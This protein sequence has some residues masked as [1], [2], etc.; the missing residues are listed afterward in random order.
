MKRTWKQIGSLILS[1]C[2]VMTMLPTTAFAETGTKDSGAGLGTSGEITAFAALDA[3]IAAQTVE[4]GTAEEELNLPTELTV[5]VTRTVTVTTGSA[6]TADVSG[7]DTATD[8][9]AQEPETQ[10][11]TQKIAEE[12]TVDVSGWTSAPAYDGDTEGDYVFTPTLALPDGVTLATGVSAPQ[13]T[14]TVGAVAPMA[15]L[16]STGDTV[17]ITGKDISTIQSAIAN[18]LSSNSTVTVEGTKTGV[19]EA[20]ELT[21][22]ENKTVIWQATYTG[23]NAFISLVGKGSFEVAAGGDINNASTNATISSGGD[24]TVSG[25]TVSSAA[26]NTIE[27]S[28]NITVSDG[29]VSTAGEGGYAINSDGNG[30]VTVEGG[31]VSATGQN[32]NA[33]NS[34]GNGNVTV[35]GGTVSATGQNG[36]AIKSYGN[37]NITVEGGTVSATTGR[38]IYANGS[39][40]TVIVSGGTV[41]NAIEAPGTS[42]TVIV[43]GGTVSSATGGNAILA[44]GASATVTV[45]GGTV[46]ATEGIAILAT[47]ASA[48]V[49]VND[50]V[51]FAYKSEIRNVNNQAVIIS[52]SASIN[53]PGVVLGWDTQTTTYAANATTDI[54][55]EPATATAYWDNSAGVGGIRYAN[56]T[57]TG[58]LPVEGV[59]V[60][61]ASAPQALPVPAAPTLAWNQDD[62]FTLSWPAVPNAM[63][64]QVRIYKDGTKFYENFTTAN[65]LPDGEFQDAGSYTFSVAAIGD[66]VNYLS[67]QHSPQSV[68]YVYPRVSTGVT[69]TMDIGG[70]TDV[71]L[72]SNHSGTGWAW[73]ATTAT[74]TLS[75]GY[76]GGRIAII[77]AAS[78]TVNLVYTGAVSINASD[79]DSAIHCS[80]SLSISGTDGTLALTSPSYAL[81]A[82]GDLEITGGTV[83]AAATGADGSG[84]ASQ[85]SNITIS[86]SANVTASGA[87]TG[88]SYGIRVQ[89]GDLTIST[90]GTVTATGKQYGIC[91]T[92]TTISG[93]TVKLN[94]SKPKPDDSNNTVIN[95][96]TVIYNNGTPP[97]ITGISP[98]SGVL[99]GGT[100]VT[101]T[102]TGFAAG[103]TVKIG[104]AAA[105]G[106][107]VTSATEITCIVP[108][109]SVGKANVLV[110][111]SGGAMAM[112]EGFTYTVGGP[113]FFN[114]AT[115]TFNLANLPAGNTIGGSGNTAWTWGNSDKKLTLTGAGPYTLTGTAS[116]N[117]RVVANTAVD[118]TLDSASFTSDTDETAL[119]L[120][121]GGTLKVTADSQV[122]GAIRG[123]FGS[124]AI[125]LNDADLD[126]DGEY[127][128][129]DVNS[130]SLTGNGTVAAVASGGVAVNCVGDLEVGIG[131]TLSASG[132]GGLIFQD[133]FSGAA[134]VISGGGNITATGDTYYGI[135]GNSLTSSLTFDFTGSLE[136]TGATYGI[137]MLK[138]DTATVVSFVSAPR[139]LTINSVSGII[140]SSQGG[141]VALQNNANIPG[142]NEVFNA[143]GTSFPI[144]PAPA[145][146]NVLGVAVNDANK[147]QITGPG[148]SGGVSY[149]PAT[150]T[151]TLNNAVIASSAFTE[152]GIF[153]SDDLTIRLIGQN[154]IG[155]APSDPTRQDTYPIQI[156][157]NGEKS[158]SLTGDGSLTV[159]DGTT[160]IFA[161]GNLTVDIG[162]GLTVVEYGSEGL[163]CCLRAEGTLTI[164]RGNLNLTSYRSKGMKGNQIVINGGVI[165]AQTQGESGHFAFSTQPTFGGSY[166]HQVF[167]GENPASAA[168]ITSPTAATFTASKYVR[169]QPRGANLYT[170]TFNLNGGTRTGGG[171]LTQTIVSGS[172]ATAP[173]VSRSGYTF[174]GWDKAFT[175]VTSTLTV[176]A[177]WSYNGGGGNGGGSSSGGSSGSTTTTTTPGKA[178]SQP[179]TAAAPVTATSGT[180]GAASASI[181]EKAIT[182]AIAKVQ[183]DAKAQ[184]K[185]ANGI[186]VA[187]N[188]TMPKGS[189][190]LTATLTQNSLN[191]LVKAGVTSLELDGAPVSLGLDLNALKEIQKQSSG[192][193]SITI[194]PVTGLSS[195][196]KA[197]LG[198]RPVYNITISYIKDGKTVNVTSLGSGAATLSI[199]YKP[200]KNEAVGYLFGVYV[201]ANG[202]AQRIDGSAYDANSGSLLIPTGH[203]SV[204]G[205]GYTAPS[206]KFTDIGTH[207]GKEA[208]D[209]VVG[210]GLLSG[211]SKTAFAPDTAMTRGMLV[212][213]LGRL[214]GVDVKAYT[215]NSFT[216]VKADSAFRPYI[217]WA[218]KKGIVQG[219]GNQQ[220]AP[221]RAI[222]RE[223]IAVIFANY[224]KATGYK[225]PVT[226]EA[227]A[228]ADASSIGS[229]YKTA[230]TA[231]Q[232]AGI[233]MG[234]TSNQFNPKSNATRAEVSSMLH[235]YI[236]LTIDPATAQGW[237]LN[238]A[239]QWLYYK[240]GKALTG[241]QTIDGVKY[242]FETTGVL[243]TGWV[244]DGDNWR[245]Y[246]GN[247]MLVGFWDL[248]A[249]GNNKTYY[250]DT[251]GNM[252]SGKWLQ[253]DGKW[254]YFN[255]DGSL[256]KS[257]KIDGYEVDENG[258]RK[259]K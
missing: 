140:G 47:G 102:G 130:L 155:T 119:Y 7:N 188:V 229:T 222:T 122:T 211:T 256:A 75:S 215:T 205:V 230:V 24:V 6:V 164:N 101:I 40:S 171:E 11:E 173:T 90:T 150:K 172:S 78:D 18:V 19:S 237:A 238:D 161:V 193:I 82:V 175:N 99:A 177:S 212:T 120:P 136:I 52:D 114:P 127:G 93:G 240:D 246:S 98:N 23:T 41:S 176:T 37:G 162:G 9:E 63:Q 67:S 72:T 39:N 258:V 87:G 105:T 26:G 163:A 116:G 64:Y 36:N 29:T 250:F 48:T 180:N 59:T 208:I 125:V 198:N 209:Y 243:K 204:Y 182:D 166:D 167:A 257:T 221:D 154:R 179:I 138:T 181:P 80:G 213:A 97:Q 194:A 151:L 225:L 236:K 65:E 118:L 197:L 86:G 199:P 50:G 259:T 249:N 3:D 158:V 132:T 66:G 14:V 219:I 108:P 148:I 147:D 30:N 55:K 70:Q 96:G 187:L 123:A 84:I 25:G 103:A 21:I 107:N 53:D 210:R 5:T 85:N 61:G 42:A 16:A 8:S 110:E 76:T 131:C 17:D 49:E 186:T 248:G 81:Y 206:A 91:A 34:Y 121:Q 27:A 216:D 226:R 111:T 13:I 69:G 74:L 92:T 195:E 115:A 10:E 77:C 185:T 143:G 227:T 22:L 190:S 196:A 43:S 100:S 117:M 217:E 191:S 133:S 202:K 73:D 245:F 218:Y 183:A 139:S 33:I 12:A 83:N 220:F 134:P 255:A 51:V 135:A 44:T 207:W 31:T 201:D 15:R 224:A 28:G 144:A 241:T 79:G 165:S 184:G 189:T 128:V 20:L 178:P 89:V 247:I 228:Y 32:G 62:S 38:A 233:M 71:S 4:T 242:F 146:L 35:E 235:R 174:T 253:I 234:G 214:A 254:Y 112:T 113:V 60:T 156:G 200:G 94:G 223:E 251:Y 104:G 58:F 45:S 126:V 124:L 252:V 145:Y 68:V 56:G 203:F 157:I 192:N 170:V 1:V 95:G 160:G 239:G 109:G 159:Y 141:T 169:I 88:D 231:M 46:S 244:K 142:L 129:I 57:N 153:S 106:V 54:V 168:E 152:Y 137:D 2:M 232:Q 149:D